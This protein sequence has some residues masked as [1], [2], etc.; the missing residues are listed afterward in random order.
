MSPQGDA[1]FL[2]S[3]LI[4]NTGGEIAVVHARTIEQHYGPQ[5]SAW[6]MTLA[7]N[8]TNHLAAVKPRQSYIVSYQPEMQC[9]LAIRRDLA[10]EA[11][12]AGTLS[13]NR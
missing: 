2:L 6:L 3:A 10:S 5:D 13:L 4:T 8:T 11:K 12:R 7:R 9:F 1:L